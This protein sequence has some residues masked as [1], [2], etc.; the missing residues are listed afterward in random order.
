VSSNRNKV[1]EFE[2]LLGFKLTSVS[3]ELPPVSPLAIYSPATPAWCP[4][5]RLVRMAA[6]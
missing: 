1:A 3:L 4:R 6:G 2:S 5:W